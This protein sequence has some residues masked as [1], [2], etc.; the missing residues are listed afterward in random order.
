MVPDTCVKFGV[1]KKSGSP[2]M[3]SKG[4]KNGAFRL[5]LQGISLVRA[6]FWTEMGCY[7]P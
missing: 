3:G 1:Q 4:V 2:D 7:G 6:D 5:Y